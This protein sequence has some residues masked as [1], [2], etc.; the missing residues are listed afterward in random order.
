M[1]RTRTSCLYERCITNTRENGR[2][3][4]LDV[5]DYRI[6]SQAPTCSDGEHIRTPSR[7]DCSLSTEIE[8]EQVKCVQ[9]MAGNIMIGKI[10]DMP[11]VGLDTR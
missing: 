2:L 5:V 6:E 1:L 8:S 4:K 9:L 11:A 10:L 3:G 7:A